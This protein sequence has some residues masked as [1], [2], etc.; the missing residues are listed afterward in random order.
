M[1]TYV[2]SGL[3][4]I[5]G[6]HRLLNVGEVWRLLMSRIIFLFLA[7]SFIVFIMAAC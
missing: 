4:V 5:G 3:T 6:G 1:V 2:L 7:V